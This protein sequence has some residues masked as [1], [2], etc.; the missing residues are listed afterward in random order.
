M[1]RVASFYFFFLVWHS[2]AVYFQGSRSDLDPCIFYPT[3][4]YVLW[5]FPCYISRLPGLQ[6]LAILVLA[7]VYFLCLGPW[8]RGFALQFTGVLAPASEPTLTIYTDSFLT[9]FILHLRSLIFFYFFFFCS[10]KYS[11]PLLFF[12]FFSF[13]SVHFRQNGPY[14]EGRFGW[15]QSFFG[16]W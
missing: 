14:P 3:V 7:P 13:F 9:F 12:L 2:C 15:R 16:Y 11:Y 10:L 8:N 4:S 1:V 5:I 6:C